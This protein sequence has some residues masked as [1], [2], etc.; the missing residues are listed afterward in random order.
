LCGASSFA[1]HEKPLLTTVAG[2]I[3]VLVIRLLLA[4]PGRR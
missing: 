1:G 3:G 4:V 2:L